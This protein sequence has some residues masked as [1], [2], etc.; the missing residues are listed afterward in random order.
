MHTDLG[1]LKTLFL[2][3][4]RRQMMLLSLGLVLAALLE[5]VGLG[6]IPAFVNLLIDPDRVLGL[7]PAGIG[8]WLGSAEQTSV[9]LAG[10][11]T[12]VALFLIK[13]LYLAALI[14]AT[15]HIVRNATVTVSTRLF[16][17]YL[18]SPFTFHLQRNP[19]QLIRNTT[20]EAGQAVNL[21]STA[22]KMLR[23]MLMLFVVFALL[24]LMD[25]L[26][27]LLV[28]L[29]LGTASM[30]FYHAVRNALGERGRLAQG[31]RAAQVKAVNQGLGAIKDAKIL[32]REGAMLA[33]F[34]RE[35][36]GIH[37]HEQYSS[38]VR[39]M[40]RLFL[41]VLAITAVLVVTAAFVLF[42]RPVDEMLPVLALLAVA[43]VRMVPAFN[44]IATA[45]AAIRYQRPSLELVC[46][47]LA[48]LE[49]ALDK[50][51]GQPATDAAPLREA[52]RVEHVD[53]VYPG[54]RAKALDDIDLTIRAGEAVALIGASG[55]GKSTLVDV[56]LGL[57]QPTAGR[58]TIDGRDL[59]DDPTAWQRQIGYIPQDIY[60]LDDTVRRNIAFGLDDGEIDEAAVLAALRAA[61]LDRFLA[62]LPEGLDTVIGNRGIRLSGGQRQR[63]GIARALYHNPS[64][65]V[66]DEATSALD[67][68]TE[69]D[70]IAAINGLRS[71]HTLI[72]IAHRLS[73]VSGCDRL[74]QMEGGKIVETGSFAELSSRH[75]ELWHTAA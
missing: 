59:R 15:E 47:E 54:G 57:L 24:L 37:H 8:A 73:T 7:L 9:V 14:F 66:M 35:I 27:S 23:E 6:S 50:R 49:P 43:V 65:L 36:S 45:L 51:H 13:N 38:V 40:P 46:D 75:G 32:G 74:Y 69:R 42:G 56:M 12:L 11:G 39:Q 3:R 2:P 33:T 41:E 5:M 58:V 67:S 68:E 31:H 1:C 53:Y 72:M 16:R 26:V 34:S 44:G 63:V 30:A 62:T 18:F 61:Q 21:V 10:A 25:P 22:M 52:I 20:V 19:A 28:F 64:V 4:Q 55:A 29:L 70:V 71:D 17:A 60:L 48:T